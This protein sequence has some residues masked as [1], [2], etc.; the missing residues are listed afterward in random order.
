MV[1]T[2]LLIRIHILLITDADTVQCPTGCE[3]KSATK[4][5]W[6]THA[7]DLLSGIH[8]SNPLWKFHSSRIGKQ[9]CDTKNRHVCCCGPDQVSPDKCKSKEKCLELFNSFNLL[10]I[11]FLQFIYLYE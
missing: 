6:S 1:Q 5:H 4:C 9:I 2:L 11:F 7:I 3:C 10:N 8:A